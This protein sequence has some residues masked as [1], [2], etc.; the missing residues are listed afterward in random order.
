MKQKQ[1]SPHW[2]ESYS[3]EEGLSISPKGALLF[4]GHLL[5]DSPVPT[6][7]YAYSLPMVVKNYLQMHDAL[8]M[9]GVPF[10]IYYAMKANRLPE[11]LRTVFEHCPDAGID[12]CSPRE[13]TLALATGFP[14]ERISFTAS[15]LSERDLESLAEHQGRVHLNLDTRSAITRWDVALTRAGV[16]RD[17]KER[18]KIGL[19][20]DP[21]AK[22]GWGENLQYGS[23]KFGFSL[24][25]I[26]EVANFAADHGFVVDTLHLHAGWALQSG[27][28]VEV[29][30]TFQALAAAASIVKVF[31]FFF[32]AT[33]K[34][35]EIK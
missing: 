21:V 25:E 34:S 3:C 5:S 7:F 20:I 35:S 1:L 28:E 2:W 32:F 8:T 4:N 15:F 27:N 16:A 17:W 10:Q 11:I 6:P 22:V 31:F 26:V 29:G 9:I 12:C 14:R 24:E 23:S 18:R 19:R 13:V 33:Q 30:K